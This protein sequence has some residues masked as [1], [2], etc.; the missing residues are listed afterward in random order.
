MKYYVIKFHII[1]VLSLGVH[2]RRLNNY[3]ALI[4]SIYPNLI[5]PLIIIST[6]AV[7]KTGLF[8]EL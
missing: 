5:R 4:I 8:S 3:I 2:T 6:A 1:R 7:K